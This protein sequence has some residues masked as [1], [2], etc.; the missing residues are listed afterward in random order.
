MLPDSWSCRL[1]SPLLLLHLLPRF[2]CTSLIATRSGPSFENSFFWLCHGCSPATS[3]SFGKWIPLSSMVTS[4]RTP[5]APL[6]TA[7]MTTAPLQFTEKWDSAHTYFFFL[8]EPELSEEIPFNRNLPP[9]ARICPN[10]T[11][12][13]PSLLLTLLH[14]PRLEVQCRFSE[15]SGWSPPFLTTE[16]TEGPCPTTN[17]LI[18]ST[19]PSAGKPCDLLFPLSKIIGFFCYLAYPPFSCASRICAP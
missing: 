4:P 17:L 3:S 2:F 11:G 16:R 7:L 8:G 12:Y 18:V 15:A 1:V 5:A 13:N 19:T 9:S 10:L 14:K 6:S